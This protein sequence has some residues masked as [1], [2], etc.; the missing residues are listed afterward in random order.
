MKTKALIN[1]AVTAQLICAFVFA[2]AKTQV[3]YEAAHLQAEAVEKK[4]LAERQNQQKL[5]KHHGHH[6]HRMEIWVRNDGTSCQDQVDDNYDEDLS[7]L[8]AVV[9][10]FLITILRYIDKIQH[11]DAKKNGETQSL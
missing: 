8:D 7:K 5:R 2:Y 10:S 1:S 9:V 3:S 4:R 11:M 6:R